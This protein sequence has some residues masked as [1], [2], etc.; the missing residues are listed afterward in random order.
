MVSGVDAAGGS[1]VPCGGSS[2]S[3]VVTG[4]V[5]AGGG[6]VGSCASPWACPGPSGSVL[7]AVGGGSSGFSL[8]SY[9]RPKPTKHTTVTTAAAMHTRPAFVSRCLTFR[10]ARM[11]PAA[12]AT[13]TPK[14]K[15]VLKNIAIVIPP[16][17]KYRDAAL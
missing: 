15:T 17:K 10:T 5:V 3:V 13:M 9:V 7:L 12:A 14:N 8:G 1:V 2:G 6:S 4:G 16:M 11:I